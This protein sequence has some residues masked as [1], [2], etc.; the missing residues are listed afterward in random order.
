MTPFLRLTQIIIMQG[1]CDETECKNNSLFTKGFFRSRNKCT[2][3]GKTKLRN[4]KLTQI[5]AFFVVSKL[6]IIQCVQTKMS[7]SFCLFLKLQGWDIFHLKG[8]IHSSVWV[9]KIFLYDIREPSYKQKKMGYQVSNLL[10]IGQ[11]C[12]LKSD[13]QYCFPYISAPLYCTEMGLNLKHA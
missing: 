2:Y 4:S 7:R 5:M 11:S 12:V 8:G 6:Y 1:L 10:D 3:I 9:T 13:V